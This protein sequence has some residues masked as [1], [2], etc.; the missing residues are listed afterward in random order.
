MLHFSLSINRFASF[1]RI[2]AL[3]SHSNMADVFQLNDNKFGLTESTELAEPARPSRAAAQKAAANIRDTAVAGSRRP[4]GSGIATVTP[5]AVAAAAAAVGGGGGVLTG[6][7]VNTIA[8]IVSHILDARAASAAA[9]ASGDIADVNAL[10]PVT[11]RPSRHLA[12]P[13]AAGP[14]I[15]G[16][17]RDQMRGA[18]AERKVER[19]QP[20]RAP[21]NAT[22][23]TAPVAR[24]A[25]SFPVDDDDDDDRIDDDVDALGDVRPAPP[26][27][28]ARASGQATVGTGARHARNMLRVA[29]NTGGHDKPFVMWHRYHTWK[30]AGDDMQANVL[31]RSFDMMI[32]EL[33]DDVV[34]YDFFEFLARRL[35]A[36]TVHNDGHGWDVA[37]HFEWNG[38]QEWTTP[39]VMVTAMKHAA[40][41][42]KVS[43]SAN[44]NYNDNSSTGTKNKRK[45]K[46]G[47]R[48]RGRGG[49]GGAQS[50]GGGGGARSSSNK[51][52]T[53]AG[54][55]SKKG[56]SAGGG[57]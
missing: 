34:E 14:D 15:I 39:D 51:S 49:G 12:E 19:K 28:G 50:S 46:R 35:Q 26:I 32:D 48:G 38:E 13:S 29:R 8:A 2:F 3:R 11:I 4:S 33:G 40:L 6:S 5:V 47:G 20:P 24:V 57:R 44:N 45:N 53:A 55:G 52:T 7:D 21:A 22:R 42:K 27:R 17:L 37:R 18:T 36:V 10:P 23:P 43:P 1:T 54:G 31:C 9:Y 16:S 30:V 41:A 56:T 25:V